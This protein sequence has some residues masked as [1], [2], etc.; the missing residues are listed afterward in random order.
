MAYTKL[1]KHCNIEKPLTDF[2]IRKDNSKYRNECKKCETQKHNEYYHKN[3][4]HIKEY[5]AKYYLKH[6]EEIKQK[7]IDF[8]NSNKDSIRERRKELRL[9]NIDHIR[10]LARKSNKNNR[11]II[12]AKEKERLKNDSLFRIKKMIRQN[13]RISFKKKKY[14][15]NETTENIL[16]CDFEYFYKHLLQTYKNNYGCEWDNIEKIHIDHVIPLAAAHTE[17]DVKKLCHYTNLQLLKEKDN[18]YKGANV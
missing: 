6:N 17:E 4:E 3:K 13:I 15:K 16:G 12:S 8:Y 14:F 2:R 1:C 11:T 18:L 9:E 5:R 10:E 7:N